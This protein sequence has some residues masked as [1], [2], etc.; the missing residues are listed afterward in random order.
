MHPDTT[1]IP[2]STPEVNQVASTNGKNGNHSNITAL[3]D[4]GL[5]NPAQP[6]LLTLPTHDEGNAQCVLALHPH[7]FHHNESLGW[8]Q[9]NKTHWTREGAEA[10]L[11]RAIVD[12][13]TAR[14][15]A[16]LKSGQADKHSDLIK[17]SVPNS[18]KVM[19]AKSLFRSLV[20]TSPS[21]FD[22]D[23]NL[24]NC[25]NGVV[26]L[27]TGQIIPHSSIHKFMHCTA[28]PYQPNADIKN[29]VLWLNSTVGEEQALFLKLAAGYSLT[30]HTREEIMFY[31]FGPPRS[32]KGTLIEA[33]LS[34]L[35][36]PLAL[37]TKFSTFT[38]ERN[39]DTQNFD[40]APMQPCRV[41]AAS[42][43]N[44]YER[45]NEAKLKN[46]TGGDTISCAFKFGNPFS[47]RP[48]FKIWLS[49]NHPVNADP[50][51]DA[52]WGRIRV[53]HFQQSHLGKENKLLKQSMRSPENLAAVLAWAVQG[54]MEWYA[55]GSAGLQETKVSHSLKSEH[56]AELDDV[57]A[58]IDDY[59]TK[60]AGIFCS[61][62]SL[63][64]SYE[65]WCKSN[66][67]TPKLA[68]R[69]GQTLKRKGFADGRQRVDGQL[70][71]GYLG[72][73]VNIPT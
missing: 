20:Y 69:F 55:L 3:V 25:P 59:C 39:G 12:T 48:Q 11:E 36:A 42:E 71:R 70:T 4:A 54:A 23:P 72:L 67:H 24:L 51:D 33:I 66:G 30:G 37:A 65:N 61:N 41:V 8:L 6:M 7:R 32:G 22:A 19:G 5:I 14:I 28:V 40:L 57:Q 47:Y 16:A 58:W 35:G 68:K 56:R 34:A 1:N 43:S 64:R 73:T 2:Q 10:T 53:I 17:K 52:V 49:S 15:D 50:D 45:F 31:L 9:N 27:R 63:Y 44:S 13:L 60:H 62:S 29:W 18:S 38:A 21:T 46:V 26:D